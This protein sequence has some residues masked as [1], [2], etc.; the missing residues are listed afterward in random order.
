MLWAL[1]AELNDE[2]DLCEGAEGFWRRQHAAADW[3]IVAEKLTAR[4]KQQKSARGD[5]SF[6]ST[7]RRDRL[8]DWLIMAL[9]NAD[10]K[11]ELIPL[12]EREA[13]ETG[14]Y[15]R[16]VN[17][18]KEA[19]RWQ[20]A[21][22]WIHKGIEATQKRTPG[23]A[24]QLRTA[25]REIREREQDWPRVAA[26]YAEDFFERPSLPTFQAL[27]QAATKAAVWSPVRAAAMDYL[28]TGALPQTLGTAKNTKQKTT[29]SWPL[30]DSG[31][32]MASE[33]AQ[34]PAPMIE[35]LIDL[36]IAEQRPDDVLR[37]YNQRKPQTASWTWGYGGSDDDKIAQAIVDLHPDRAIAIWKKMAEELI[38]QA[39]TKSYESAATY[40][41]KVLRVMKERKQAQEW[42]TYLAGVRQANARKRRLVEILDRLEK[43]RI[44][45]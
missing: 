18:L 44:L 32:H 8:T 12:C 6:S 26:F 10:R 20:E 38:A 19:K 40:L 17:Y 16:L 5:D 22:E 35:T 4:L 1:D 13:E 2:Y 29:P 30:P 43:R 24:D 7:Y 25:L 23:I 28:E 27:Q 45:G 34:A 9:E 15:L 33:H 36:A 42:E 41:R 31:M 11:D 21:E 14:S 39:N 3:N 37:W